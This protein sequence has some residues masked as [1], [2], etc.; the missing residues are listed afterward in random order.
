MNQPTHYTLSER[1]LYIEQWKSS[2]LDLRTFSKQT[3]V[4][5]TSLRYW[6]YGK[7]PKVEKPKSAGFLPVRV[8]EEYNSD[9]ELTLELPTGMRMTLRGSITPSYLKALIS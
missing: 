6:A 5:L 2:K 4:P 9:L 3:G 1:I 7:K 8:S